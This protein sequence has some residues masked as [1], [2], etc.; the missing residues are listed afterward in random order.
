M[1]S[2]QKQFHT[3]VEVKEAEKITTPLGV[4][5][6]MLGYEGSKSVSDA[7]GTAVSLVSTLFNSIKSQRLARVRDLL[8]AIVSG[9]PDK[10]RV[11]LEEDSSVLLEKLEEKEF[12]I[13]PTCHKFNLKPYQA[14]L[15]VDDT[16]M[17]EMIKPYF[18]RL[19]DEKEADRQY[20]E[21]YPQGWKEAEEKKMETDF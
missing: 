16:Q 21:Q 6:K 12:V 13:A 2:S 14:A 11:I 19:G 3:D 1:F 18:S 15:S 9:N 4:V 20:E 10:V 7:A 8:T 5:N 17:A